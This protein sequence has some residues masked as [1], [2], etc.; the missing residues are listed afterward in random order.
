MPSTMPTPSSPARWGSSEKYSKLRP[1]SGERF[2]LIPGP[3]MTDRLQ[4]RASRPNATPTRRSSSGFQLDAIADAVGK[5]VAGS[6]PASPT[7]SPSPGWAR[8]P[9]GPS[10]TMIF[11]M[12][13]RSTGVVYQNAEPLVRDAFS[14]RVSWVSRELMSKVTRGSYLG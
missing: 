14:A 8:S 1:H 7:W 3:R 13:S 2:M 9:W 6:D 4:A 5:H 12:P 11:G 10:D